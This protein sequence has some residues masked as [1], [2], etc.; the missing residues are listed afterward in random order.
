M[1]GSRSF[2]LDLFKIST[3]VFFLGAVICREAYRRMVGKASRECNG[4]G[5]LDMSPGL[6]TQRISPPQSLHLFFLWAGVGRGAS[7]GLASPPTSDSGRICLLPRLPR[8]AS[9]PGH[10]GVALFAFSGVTHIPLNPITGAFHISV[11]HINCQ[12]F[13][14]IVMLG[15]RSGLN[16]QDFLKQIADFLKLIMGYPSHS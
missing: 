2:D 9:T 1:S 10:A 8:N 13:S 15:T 4:F 7:T 16:R 3:P 6:E 14:E 5:V 12:N 11:R